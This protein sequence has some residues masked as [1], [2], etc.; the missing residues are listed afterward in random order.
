MSNHLGIN[1]ILDVQVLT[2]L[3]IGSGRKLIAGFDFAVSGGM[4]YRL[5]EDAIL[6]ERWPDEPTLQKKLVGQ[7]L[8]EL[9]EPGD[10]RAHP[11]YFRYSLKGQ[12]A[13]REIVECI[14]DVSGQ[15][16]VPGS[17]LKGALRTALLRA[18]SE[19]AKIVFKRSDFGRSGGPREA[20]QAGQRLEQEA[21]GN[22]PNHDILRALI[23][24]DS[25]PAPTAALTLQRVQMVPQ[26]QI[27]VEAIARG[28]RLTAPLRL[29]TWL[30]QRKDGA[31]DWSARMRQIASHVA[32][33]AQFVARSR[34]AH[35]YE[36]HSRRG[37]A[38]AAS[39]YAGLADQ[40]VANWPKNEFLI[41]VGFA[42]G[43]RAKTVLG[44][45]EDTDPLLEQ[46][47]HDFSLDR[48]GGKQSRG[49]VRGQPFPKARHLAWVA[50]NPALPMG[51]LRVR[52]VELG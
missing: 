39:F 38:Q 36:Y 33:S 17:S 2:P 9:L 35:E 44:G 48:G 43:W 6:V 26:L 47:V 37:D 23:V 50:G 22:D 4:T 51:W 12:P 16:Y 15:P 19:D 52:M 20:K 28:T 30:L 29:D 24:G 27:D 11:E 3:H 7:P 13:M 32:Q 45:L 34:I 21:F 10:Y 46:V 40:V 42:I 1:Y 49:Y 25:Q 5:N 41:Q 31:L 18:A 8:A 14:R